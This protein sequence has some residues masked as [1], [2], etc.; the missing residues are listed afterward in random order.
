VTAG[1]TQAPSGAPG[2]LLGLRA[3]IDA[4]DDVLLGLLCRRAG[5]AAA[6]GAM[7][8]PPPLRD[9]GREAAVLERL[10]AANPGPLPDAA[11]ARIF[12]EIFR[13]CLEAQADP[14]AAR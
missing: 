3:E 7:K 2:T 9:A 12:G 8:G 10:A 11:I 14:S 1:A 13:A 5:I 4:I 6:L